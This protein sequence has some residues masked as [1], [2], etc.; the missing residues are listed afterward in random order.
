VRTKG[1]VG[2]LYTIYNNKTDMPVIID[3][4]AEESAK[5]MK[6]TLATFYPTVTR[7]KTGENKKWY[8]ETLRIGDL[9][10]EY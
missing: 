5:A 2:K 9:V 6:M 1:S 3:G 8:V 10:D 7:A 4:T